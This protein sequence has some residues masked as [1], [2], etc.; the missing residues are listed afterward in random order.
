MESPFT[1]APADSVM[2]ISLHP[3]SA[4]KSAKVDFFSYS[5]ASRG[6]GSLTIRDLNEVIAR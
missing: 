3:D 6:R 4:E 5:S 2:G 1:D